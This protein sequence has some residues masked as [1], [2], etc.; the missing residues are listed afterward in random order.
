MKPRNLVVPTAFLEQQQSQSSQNQLSR[1]QSSK[2]K[3]QVNK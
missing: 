2:Q 3:G 1:N